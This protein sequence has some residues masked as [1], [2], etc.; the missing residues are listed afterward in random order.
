MSAYEKGAGYENGPA[1]I[2]RAVGELVGI[3]SR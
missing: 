1:V 3:S 2:S